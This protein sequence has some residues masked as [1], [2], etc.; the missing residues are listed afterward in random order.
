MGNSLKSN[1][2][3][4]IRDDYDKKHTFNIDTFKVHH[5][6]VFIFFKTKPFYSNGIQL[7]IYREKRNNPTEYI[8]NIE[9]TF[10]DKKKLIYNKFGDKEFY[11]YIETFPD[12]IKVSIRL[13]MD[14]K[15]S[16]V[17]FKFLSKNL[18]KIN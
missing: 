14:Y 9:T 15:I 3:C 11:E 2:K 1:T 10:E 5:K 7:F 12:N 16:L 13:T 6:E 8:V 4:Y 18:Y 17:V